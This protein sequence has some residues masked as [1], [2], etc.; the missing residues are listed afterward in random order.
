MKTILLLASLIAAIIGPGTGPNFDAAKFVLPND[1]KVLVAVEGYDDSKC[2][3]YAFE[4]TSAE[5]TEKWELRLSADGNMGRGDMNNYR[6]RGDGTTPIGVWQLNTPFGQLPAQ[7]G[8]PSDYIQV[9][10][11]YV[12]TDETNRLVKDTTHS[13]EGE[14]VGTSQ[15]AG[16]YDYCLDAGYNRKAYPNKGSALF[17]HCQG[18]SSGGSSGCVK[19][20]RDTMAEIMKLY[21][22]YGEGKCYIAQAPAKS[23]TKLYNAYGVCNGL[24]PD[25]EF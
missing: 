16:Y 13:L 2:K 5:G 20:P 10:Q 23:M 24:S 25:G 8:F 4:K 3:V 12:W 21:G 18:P 14:W 6:K 1:A 19:V 9:N 17:L 11:D 15:Y 7:E 22:K